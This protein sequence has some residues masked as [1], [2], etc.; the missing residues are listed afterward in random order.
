MAGYQDYEDSVAAE[1]LLIDEVLPIKT[2]RMTGGRLLSD[3]YLNQENSAAVPT[4]YSGA[5]Q[6]TGR[7]TETRR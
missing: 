4:T 3:G 6:T 7:A 1:A 2:T 5:A